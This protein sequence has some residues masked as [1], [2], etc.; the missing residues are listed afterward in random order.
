LRAIIE[1]ATCRGDVVH[2]VEAAEDRFFA[3]SIDLLCFL[4]FNGHFNRLNPAWERTLGFTRGVDG[5][6][7]HPVRPPG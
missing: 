6:A 4:G 2:A 5:A 3:S 7:L 1:L